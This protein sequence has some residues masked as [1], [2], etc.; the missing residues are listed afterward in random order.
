MV[1][2]YAAYRR[3]V[4]E[5]YP[6]VPQLQLGGIG[7]YLDEGLAGG[8]TFFYV[9]CSHDPAGN[10]HQLS[11][12]TNAGTLGEPSPPPNLDGRLY[13]PLVRRR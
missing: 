2:G 12:E 1:A 9:L 11:P 5:V 10:E 7:S 4:V 6:D 8:E 13:L 3:Q